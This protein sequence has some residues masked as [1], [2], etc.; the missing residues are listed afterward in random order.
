MIVSSKVMHRALQLLEAGLPYCLCTVVDARGSVPGRPGAKMIVTADGHAFGTVGGAGLEEQTKA[1][2]LRCLQTRR[3]RIE[4]FDLSRFKPQGLDSLCG[5]S[6]DIMLEFVPGRPHVLICGGGHVGLEVARL[7][8][9]LEYLYS[10]F[11]E[12][13]EYS[14]PE[15]FANAR[16]HHTHKALEFFAEAQ[17]EPYSHVVLLGHSYRVDTD[18]LAQLLKRYTGYVGLICSRLK[19][20][21]MFDSLLSQGVTAADLDRIEAPVG[22]DI[23]AESPAE[24]AVAIMASVIRSH[25]QATAASPDEVRNARQAS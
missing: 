6:V 17:L 12:R 3:S 18:V 5:G 19:R 24:I 1:L 22:V 15:R 21:Q 25:K 7:C 9:Q 20:K 13:P 11:D 8:E 4:H 10:V 16:C 14:S 2:A 23:G